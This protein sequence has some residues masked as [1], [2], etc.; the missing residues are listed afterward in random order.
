MEPIFF[1]LTVDEK[2]KQVCLVDLPTHQTDW[3]IRSIADALATHYASKLEQTDLLILRPDVG[4]PLPNTDEYSDKLPILARKIPQPV[5]HMLYSFNFEHRLSENSTTRHAKVQ[6]STETRASIIKGIREGEFKHYVDDSDALLPARKGFVYRAP[7]GH[8]VRQFLRVGNI[9]KNRQALD[10]AFFWMLPFLKGR[11][12]IIADTWSISSIAINAARLLRNYPGG[13]DCRVDFLP[14]YF[15][16]SLHSR[17]NAKTVLRYADRNRGSILMLFSAVRSGRSLEHVQEALSEIRPAADIKYLAIYSLD[18]GVGDPVPINVLCA[19]LKGFE[20]VEKRGAIIRIDSGSFFPM[21]AKDKPLMIGDA[22]GKRNYNF[23][24]KYQGL[25][26]FRMHRNVADTDG[27]KLR[28]HAFDINIEALLQSQI[29]LDQFHEKLRSLPDLSAIVVPPHKAG[30]SMGN[31]AKE[32]LKSTRGQAPELVVHADLDLQDNSLKPIFET[33]TLQSELLILDDV[34]TTGQRLNRFQANL[35]SWNFQG[36]VTYMVGVARP[37]DEERWAY[38][39]RNLRMRKGDR[40]NDV[41]CLEKIVLPDWDM[42]ECPWCLEYEWLSEMIETSGFGEEGLKRAIERRELL[43]QAADGEGLVS[44]VF[45]IPPQRQ[46]PTITPR[47]I[48]LPNVDATEAD[49]AASVAGAI[50]RMR[51]EPE[52]GQRLKADFLQPR[53]LDPHNFLGPDPRYND[54]VLRMAVLRS[55]LPSELRRWDDGE[56]T[57]RSRYL[58]SAFVDDQCCFALELTVAIAQ[59][60]FPLIEDG[61]V[62]LA[63]IQ[64]PEAQEILRSTLKKQ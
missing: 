28:H 45:W 41:E 19:R 37:D 56:E 15:D 8:Y 30:K 57:L 20:D 25:Q 49:I 47:S 6:Y 11:S 39:V 55:A 2:N 31:A 13:R 24:E 16:G 9:Q 42:A 50:Q 10:A 17:H 59:G 43:E 40:A 38:R 3:N 14:E 48:F 44:N 58:G 26:A 21:T 4:A 33:T 51:T 27:K 1:E 29:F 64:P 34:S 54:L 18:G 32:F 61:D 35:R 46:R 53:V 36:H 63:A 12:T 60:K 52:D 62:D 7:S 23:F 22:H 5:I